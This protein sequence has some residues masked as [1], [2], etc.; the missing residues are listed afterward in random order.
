[1]RFRFSEIA[2]ERI[3]VRNADA[4]LRVV[5][6]NFC[7]ALKRGTRFRVALE[8]DQCRAE[9]GEES[10]ITRLQRSRFA[11]QFDRLRGLAALQCDEAEQV[12]RIRM[13]R[14]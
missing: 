6:I 10:P 2:R 7:C 4:S 3:A 14:F 8:L 11:Y 9:V 13:S 1:M 5:G 12:E